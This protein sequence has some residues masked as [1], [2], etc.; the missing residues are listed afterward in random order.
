[1]KYYTNGKY[2]YRVTPNGECYFKC[3]RENWTSWVYDGYAKDIIH[4][5]WYIEISK[6]EAFIELL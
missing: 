4:L 3:I 5:T 2:I 6:E 1:M